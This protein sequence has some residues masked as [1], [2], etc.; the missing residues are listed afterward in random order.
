[1]RGDSESCLGSDLDAF[2]R[3]VIGLLYHLP[4]AGYIHYHSTNKYSNTFTTS[5]SIPS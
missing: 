5:I 3:V 2:T 4:V 1:M